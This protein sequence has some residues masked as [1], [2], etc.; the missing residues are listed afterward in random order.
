MWSKLKGVVENT[1]VQVDNG[2]LSLAHFSKLL[3]TDC[4]T[5]GWMMR[6]RWSDSSLF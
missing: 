5:L 6:G 2:A 1:L 3:C 4:Y